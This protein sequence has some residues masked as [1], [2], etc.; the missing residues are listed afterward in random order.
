M[1]NFIFNQTKQNSGKTQVFVKNIH[2]PIFTKESGGGKLD[3]T[4]S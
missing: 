1:F 4:Y 2:I 3:A